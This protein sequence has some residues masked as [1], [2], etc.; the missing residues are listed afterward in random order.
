[1]PPER[2]FGHDLALTPAQTIKENAYMSERLIIERLEFQGR[3]GVTLSERHTLQPIAVDLE[4]DYPP[5]VMDRAAA[6]DDLTEAVDYATVADRI[7]VTATREPFTLVETLAE[8]L[9]I[10]LFAEF[11][12]ARVRLWVRKVAP[13]LKDV[14]G[15]VGVRVDRMRPLPTARYT[16]PQP[17]RFLTEQIHRLPKGT[18]LDVATGYGRNALYLAAQ[19][20]TVEGVDLDEQALA[21]LATAAKDRNLANLTVRRVDLEVN[22]AAPPDLGKERYDVVL[23]FLYLYRPLFPA[24]L[25]ALKPGGVLLYE[26][27]LIENYLRHQHPRRKEFCL[28]HNEL[29]RLTAGSR[30]LHYD[31]GEHFMTQADEPGQGSAFTARLLAQK[32]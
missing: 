9:T 3:C 29:L 7:L 25:R 6:K 21:S 13:P 11:P 4:L 1:V 30:I 17:A 32:E 19:G 31:E 28:I 27:F 5:Y 20:F 24:L 26:T 22:P 8:R 15:S 18:T 23:V 14:R 2:F 12:V 10:M 16:G